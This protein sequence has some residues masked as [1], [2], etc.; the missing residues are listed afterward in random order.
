[1]SGV[2]EVSE[3]MEFA[4]LRAVSWVLVKDFSSRYHNKETELFTIDP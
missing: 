4:D 2:P 1:M 3:R